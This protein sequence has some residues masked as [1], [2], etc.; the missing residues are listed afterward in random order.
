MRQ[1]PRSFQ[2][3]RES[4]RGQSPHRPALSFHLLPDRDRRAPPHPAPVGPWLSLVS[5]MG[6]RDT[7]AVLCC[8]RWAREATSRARAGTFVV[9]CRVRCPA[10]TRPGAVGLPV[11]PQTVPSVLFGLRGARSQSCPVWGPLGFSPHVATGSR[12]SAPGALE[13]LA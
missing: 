9:A 2:S 10:F 1:R 4:V 6:R 12:E 7:C 5:W 8:R 11:P 13:T 3:S